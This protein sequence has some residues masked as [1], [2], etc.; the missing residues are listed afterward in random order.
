MEEEREQVRDRRSVQEDVNKYIYFNLQIG[1]LSRLIKANWLR[2][3]ESKIVRITNKNI[4]V[5]REEE[6]DK[7]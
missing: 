3:I 5:S 6:T 7:R 1:G 2:K 4:N